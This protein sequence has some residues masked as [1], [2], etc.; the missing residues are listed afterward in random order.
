MLL[1]EFRVVIVV[2]HG[3]MKNSLIIIAM[4]EIK[5]HKSK[6]DGSNS[7]KHIHTLTSQQMVIIS[8]L[9]NT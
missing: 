8:I 3:K 7:T 1:Y 9:D 6:E 5:P 4:K 2:W